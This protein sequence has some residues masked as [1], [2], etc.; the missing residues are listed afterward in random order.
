MVGKREF[1]SDLYYRLNVFPVRV[2]PLRDR[3]EDIPP[4]VFYFAQRFAKRLRRSIESV[5]R[6]SMDL[7]CQW[8]WPGNIRELQNVIERAVILS[9]GPV[10]T[11]PRAEFETTAPIT[12]AAVT[13]E[14]A[15]RD[16]IL[17]ALADT[18]W[19]I[20]GPSGAAMRLGLKRTSL[21]STMRRL[22]IVR[23]P[24]GRPA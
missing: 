2:P 12:S 20:G 13:L 9:R 7:L 15:E 8:S 5:S 17:R 6:E 10:L 24:P 11:V 3:R 18:N 16:H 21:V 23:P 14:D 22:Q 1:R 4:L 19:V